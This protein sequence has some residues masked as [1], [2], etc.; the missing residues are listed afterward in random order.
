MLTEEFAIDLGI[1]MLAKANRLLFVT[2]NQ[3]NPVTSILCWSAVVFCA[4]E[5]IR[6]YYIMLHVVRAVHKLDFSLVIN[7]I[8]W[9]MATSGKK[10]MQW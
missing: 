5:I 6:L 9:Q 7:E 8:I 2:S 4:C 1:F 3:C 10:A